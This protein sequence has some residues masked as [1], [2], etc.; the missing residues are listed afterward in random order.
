MKH[1]HDVHDFHS[2]SILSYDIMY[3]AHVISMYHTLYIVLRFSRDCM[4]IIGR[5]HNKEKVIYLYLFVEGGAVVE[6]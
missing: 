3:V 5:M 2:K 6:V 1:R 4:K